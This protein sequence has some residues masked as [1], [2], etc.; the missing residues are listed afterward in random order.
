METSIM[1]FLDHPHVIKL[2]ETIENRTHYYIVTE[3]VKDG[4]LFDYIINKEFLEGL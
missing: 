4:D 2:H 3:I 1:K